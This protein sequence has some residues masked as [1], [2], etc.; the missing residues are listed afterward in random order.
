MERHALTLELV[1]G[2][3]AVARL[4]PGERLPDW[5]GGRPFVSITWTDAELSVVCPQEAVP[6]GVQAER[7]WCCLRVAGPLGFGMTGILA[8]LAGPLASSGVSIFVVSTY[9]TDYLMLQER[10]LDRGVD[11]LA[12]AGHTVTGHSRGSAS[13]RATDPT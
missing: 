11:A 1:A 6:P 9:D 8:S 10:D 7:G 13:V 12:R 2:R 4:D 3:Y 5:A